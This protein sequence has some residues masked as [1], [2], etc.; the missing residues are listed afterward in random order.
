MSDTTTTAIPQLHHK[1]HVGVMG[2]LGNCWCTRDKFLTPTPLTRETG[3]FLDPTREGGGGSSLSTKNTVHNSSCRQGGRGELATG[4]KWIV[5]TLLN[6]VEAPFRDLSSL[7]ALTTWL[8]QMSNVFWKGGGGTSSPSDRQDG[9]ADFDAGEGG[10]RLQE[11]ARVP[12]F[13]K[14]IFKKMRSTD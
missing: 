13:L 4:C 1:C 3:L 9:E 14:L 2:L 11:A 7:T 6:V 5:T 8:I 10:L 12:R